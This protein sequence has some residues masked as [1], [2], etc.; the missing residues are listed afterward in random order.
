MAIKLTSRE[1]AVTVLLSGD[2][3]VLLKSLVLGHT[4]PYGFSIITNG[5]EQADATRQSLRRLRDALSSST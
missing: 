4:T 3:Y 5:N 1:V 2:D